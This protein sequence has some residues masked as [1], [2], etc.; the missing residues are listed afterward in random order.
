MVDCEDD[1]ARVN[2]LKIDGIVTYR[3]ALAAG[4]PITRLRGPAFKRVHHQVY[5][6][7]DLELDDE[8]R[9]RAWMTAMPDSAALFGATA[10]AWCGIPVDPPECVQIIVPPG[11]VPRR[12]PGLEPH[13]GLGAN[14]TIV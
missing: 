4:I 14:E 8:A 10:A 11:V 7:A 3:E 6:P 5:V 1:A 9:V 2:G 13:E 12:R